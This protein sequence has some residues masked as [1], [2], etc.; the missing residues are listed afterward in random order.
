MNKETPN[1]NV[2]TPTPSPERKPTVSMTIHAT[3]ST[4][5]FQEAMLLQHA[6]EPLLLRLR[7]LFATSAPTTSNRF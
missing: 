1:A 2:D 3:C 6:V 7:G 4:Q 5:V